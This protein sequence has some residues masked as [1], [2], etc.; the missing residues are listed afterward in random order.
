MFFFRYNLEKRWILQDLP[1]S[2][3]EEEKDEQED[4][5]KSLMKFRQ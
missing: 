2:D 4:K 5:R 3:D 1:K